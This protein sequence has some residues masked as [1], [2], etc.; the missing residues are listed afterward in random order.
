M[1]KTFHIRASI[2]GMLLRKNS[3]LVG[4]LQDDAGN[5]LSPTEAKLQLMELLQQGHL[6][7]KC[8]R[9]DNWS[10]TEGCLGHE[11]VQEEAA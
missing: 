4:V 5:D 10:P 3:E 7:I 2:K 9:C 6:Y 11:T 1:S 8:G